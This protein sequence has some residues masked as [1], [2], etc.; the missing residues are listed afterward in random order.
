MLWPVRCVAWDYLKKGIWSRARRVSDA[1]PRAD[2]VEREVGRVLFE[3]GFKADLK[4]PE[5]MLRAIISTGKI[6]LGYGSRKS[7]S[8]HLRAASTSSQ[9]VFSSWR[10][11]AS[12]GSIIVNLSQAREGERL[13]DP[14]AGTCGILI[15]ACL[16]GIAGVGIEVQARLAKG[17]LCNL[18]GLDCQLISGDAKRLPFHK[19]S[20]HAAVL[21]T[22][23]GRSAKILATSK[24]LLI[25]E[26]LAELFLVIKPG[27]RMVILADR[28][29][30]DLLIKAGFEII[31][32]HT[33]SVHRSLT[34]HIFLCKKGAEEK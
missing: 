31:Q 6:V 13:L 27:R 16:I 28:P 5:M 25:K 32:K 19:S 18:D 9:A 2:E 8:K 26:S 34:R 30:D 17:A 14:F 20:F 4:H 1:S 3:M 22:P 33:D 11:H 23:Y 29:I 7:G 10:T 15:E 24:G 21:D 12:H